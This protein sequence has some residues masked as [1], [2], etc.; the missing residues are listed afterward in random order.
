MGE[1]RTGDKLTETTRSSTI[2][3]DFTSGPIMPM[4]LKFFLPFL[5]AN[6]LNSL[7]NTVDTVIIG[8]FVGS[9]GIV[10]VTVGGKMLN[11]FTNVGMAFAG[12]GQ[13][14]IG[15]IIGAKRKEEIKP[16]IGTLFT[17]MIV[18]SV[19]VAAVL[20]VF[21]EQL[22]MLM[23]TPAESFD[24]ALSYLRITS[25]G[26][27]LIFGYTAVC[28]VLRG[29]G[30][31]KGPL[32]YIAVAALFNVVGDLIFVV[33][34]HWDATGTAVATILGQGVALMFSVV[35]L[36]R[37]RA[38]FGFDFKWKSFAVN[39]RMLKVILK[40]G[41]PMVLRSFCITMTQLVLYSNVNLYGLAEATAYSIGDKI[42]RLA[43]IF[44]HSTSQAAGGM[45]A[46]NVGAGRSDRVRVIV[47][48]SAS[49]AIGAAV[50]LSALALL[51]PN[52]IFALFTDDAQV[53]AYARIFMQISCVIML[54]SAV[55]GSYEAVVT[56]TGH[57]ALNFL[58]GFLDGVVFR[59]FFSFLFA[60]VFDM[61][62]AGFFLGDALA[63][64]GPLLIGTIYYYSG[65]WLRRK[66]LVN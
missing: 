37:R 16:A 38:S 51:F 20:M 9:A 54:L 15:Q 41:F 66:K 62:A 33:C 13:V 24:A 7:Y 30:D 55:M 28:A 19:L 6:L 3:T 45:I 2:S 23:N 60:R 5:L 49:I 12:G 39:G 47:R 10:A 35:S 22:L 8:Q 18:S 61:G 21:S 36:Y 56:G 1:N 26:L 42:V 58:A 40:L 43:N 31:S 29:M 44:H 53:L 46:Q 65:A 32:I 64:L 25:A 63:R 52:A 4:L 57:S 14:L 27:P 17:L 34:F 11:L 48:Y 59:I 50:I